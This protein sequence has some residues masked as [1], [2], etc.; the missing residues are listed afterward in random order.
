MCLGD[1]YL[2]EGQLSTLAYVN[3][4]SQE[5]VVLNG[6]GETINTIPVAT[7]YVGYPTIGP[8]AELFFY[9][10]DLSDTNLTPDQAALHRVAPP[11][12]PAEVVASDPR[13]L[14]PHR[15]LDDTRLIAS[16][17]VTDSA[18]GLAVVDIMTG[19]IQPVT[20]WPN[21]VFVG[22]LPAESSTP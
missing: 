8:T 20:Q 6:Q 18:W 17:L 2:L 4:N 9:S 22:V 13:L 14:L 19:A 15:F 5:V 3:S 10:A 21:A 16:Y 1:F 7:E 11:T 12:T